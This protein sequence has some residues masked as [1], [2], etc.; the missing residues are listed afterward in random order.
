MFGGLEMWLVPAAVRVADG[1]NQGMY[2]AVLGGRLRKP[3][4]RRPSRTGNAREL[5]IDPRNDKTLLYS[6]TGCSLDSC[7]HPM[8]NRRQCCPQPF[9]RP[10]IHIRDANQA[11]YTVV[12]P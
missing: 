10:L 5:V 11:P 12:H 7:F 1:W 9:D 6:A 4:R 2:R 3:H 8:R